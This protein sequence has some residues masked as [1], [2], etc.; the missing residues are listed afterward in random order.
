MNQHDKEKEISMFLHVIWFDV[1]ILIFW[2]FKYIRLNTQWMLIYKNFAQKPILGKC[3]GIHFDSNRRSSLGYHYVNTCQRNIGFE[4]K[5]LHYFWL[6]TSCLS[7]YDLF[8][9][10][11]NLLMANIGRFWGTI[12]IIL[13]SPQKNN[14]EQETFSVFLLHWSYH[15]PK[16]CTQ[17]TLSSE[18]SYLILL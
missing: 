4:E 18:T 11:L 17:H 5:S 1:F 15:N 13:K 16:H 3:Q 2:S 7:P 8:V 12:L 14:F 10:L 6:K 9:T